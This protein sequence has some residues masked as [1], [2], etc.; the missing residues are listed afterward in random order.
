MNKFYFI[1]VNYNNSAFTISYIDSVNRLIKTEKDNIQIIIVDNLSEGHDINILK[2]YILHKD[3]VLL[4]E[5]TENIGY[6]KALNTGISTIPDKQNSLI[7]IGNNDLEFNEDFLLKLKQVEYDE[8]TLVLAPNIITKDGVHQNP[9]VVNRVS[10]F[11]KVFYKMYF[12]NYYLGKFLFIT[13]QKIK[14][15]HSNSSEENGLHE[16]KMF[17]YMGIGAC[18]ILTPNFTAIYSKL[19]DGVFMWGEEALLANQIE[20][21]NGK[22]LYDNTLLVHHHES[23]T[24]SKMSSKK[25]YYLIKESY[26]IYSKY[27]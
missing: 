2:K 3:N 12:T 6:F 16:K 1:A 21:A 24:V 26:K 23:A 15:M 7:I 8:K 17:I 20:R 11:K 22:T 10:K 27:L 9:H 18:Y 14:K 25:K 5:N 19:D 4:I 13:W